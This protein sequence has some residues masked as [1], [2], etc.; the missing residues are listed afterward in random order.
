MESSAFYPEKKQQ[1][2]QWNDYFMTFKRYINRFLL[3]NLALKSL[4]W[5]ETFPTQ[6]TIFDEIYELS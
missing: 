4:L 1:N 3:P 2:I 6:A 5:H